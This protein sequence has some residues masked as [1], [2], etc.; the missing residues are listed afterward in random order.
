MQTKT[1]ALAA[2]V[3]LGTAMM[4]TGAMAFGGNH[5]GG[6]VGGHVGGIGGGPAGGF[7]GNHFAG[8]PA[9]GGHWAGAGGRGRAWARNGA[10][11]GLGLG[12]GGLY[13]Y[14]GGPYGY[15]D[16]YYYGND[17]CG[18]PYYGYYGYGW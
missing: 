6:G 11:L 5:G 7:G 10:A 17:Y 18:S 16:P 9:G 3:A 12:L 14:G 1:L 8:G 4:G 2:A 15:C 13:A